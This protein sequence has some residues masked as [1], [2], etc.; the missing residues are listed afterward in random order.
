[1]INTLY[2]CADWPHYDLYLELSRHLPETHSSRFVSA[3]NFLIMQ[4]QDSAV[5]DRF[6]DRWDT[7]SGF[8]RQILDQTWD[9]RKTLRGLQWSEEEAV[10]LQPHQKPTI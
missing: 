7:E 2:V 4:T 3:H 6:I 5:A 8:A 10:L 1:M 9:S